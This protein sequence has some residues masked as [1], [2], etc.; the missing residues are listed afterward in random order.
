MRAGKKEDG[1]GYV[2]RDDLWDGGSERWGRI[3]YTGRLKSLG[4]YRL[5][6]AHGRLEIYF[7]VPGMSWLLVAAKARLKVVGVQRR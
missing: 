4:I 3:R 6:V 7:L 1:V 5:A 2:N